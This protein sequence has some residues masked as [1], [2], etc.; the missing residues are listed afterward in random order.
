MLAAIAFPSDLLPMPMPM[1]VLVLVLVL[2]PM[3]V[4]GQ[5]DQFSF[6]QT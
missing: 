2:V 6:I 1:L 3:L 4:L 5:P